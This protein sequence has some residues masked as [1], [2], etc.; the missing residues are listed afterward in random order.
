YRRE[1]FELYAELLDVIKNDVIKTVF[2]VQI[3]NA[4]ELDQA[5]ETITEDLGQVKDLQFKHHHIESG[6]TIPVEQVEHE[7]TVAPLRE[8]PKTGR[9]DPCHCGSGKKYKHCHGKIA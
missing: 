7:I 5:T 3:K 1:A 4:T 6:E 2:T 9:N 8:G